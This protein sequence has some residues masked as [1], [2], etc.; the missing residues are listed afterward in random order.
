MLAHEL[1]H[2]VRHD[3][4]WLIVAA[5]VEA[6]FFFQPL[7]RIARRKM[8]ETAEY[9][10]DEWA[11]RHTGSRV[12]LAKCLAE[13]A[14]WLDDGAVTSV[15]APMAGPLSP[16]RRRIARILE[17][18]A[19][20]GLGH[21]SSR[22]GLTLALLAAVAWIAP[23]VS[24]ASSDAGSTTGPDSQV[25]TP[26]LTP[27]RHRVA[28]VRPYVHDWVCRRPRVWTMPLVVDVLDGTAWWG[29]TIVDV[30]EVRRRAQEARR[31]VE[32]A[33]HRT[34]EVRRRVLE[35]QQRAMENQRQ[36]LERLRQKHEDG[37]RGVARLPCEAT[38]RDGRE[39][40]ALAEI[41]TIIGV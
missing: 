32:E 27:R 30:D 16:I 29:P 5:V 12:H 23:S 37:L 17:E 18:R 25:A 4:T 8:Q 10:A 11:V 36:A 39:N 1:A 14:G 20:A 6:V 3:A 31:R 19:A 13:V 28:T 9:L 41:P 7:N 38:S 33:R 2:V 15:A 35:A 40:D 34:H 24:R 21:P 22:I 26:V